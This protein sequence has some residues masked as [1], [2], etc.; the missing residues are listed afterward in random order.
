MIP[1]L[2]IYVAQCRREVAIWFQYRAA[3]LIWLIGAVV[4]PTVYLVVWTTVA[5]SQ[6]GQVGSYGAAD[7]AAYFIIFML[8]NHLTFTWH[9]WEYDY[10]IREGQFSALLLLPIHPIHGDIAE[11]LVYKALSLA[12][13]LPAAVVMTLVFKPAFQFQPWSL[14]LALAALGLAYLIR[15]LLGYLVAMAAFWTSRITAV[16]QLYYVAELF[17]SG[18]LTPLDLL[19]GALY[20]V[21]QVL[22]FQWGIAFPVALILGQLTPAAAWRGLGVQALWLAVILLALRLVWRRALRQYAAFGS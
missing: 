9:M 6:G 4:S 19:P 2:R 1:L 16:N 7:L 14:A 11:N 13:L 10:I 5:R 22:P 3:M 20:S 8:V 17:F 15:F 21:A 12:V 18:Q